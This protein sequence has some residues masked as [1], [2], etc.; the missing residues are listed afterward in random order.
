MVTLPTLNDALSEFFDQLL[1]QYSDAFSNWWKDVKKSMLNVLDSAKGFPIGPNPIKVLIAFSNHLL[2]IVSRFEKLLQDLLTAPRAAV[3]ETALKLALEATP[4]EWNTQ[5]VKRNRAFQD[6]C[7]AIVTGVLDG[8]S[9]GLPLPARLASLITTIK[10]KMTLVKS[11]GTPIALLLKLTVGSIL[12]I[13]LRLLDM[14]LRFISVVAAIVA[15]W[16]LWLFV[17]GVVQDPPKYLKPLGQS[18]PRLKW[19]AHRGQKELFAE[20]KYRVVRRRDPGGVKP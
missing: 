19:Y 6:T 4:P 15:V 5:V 10:S 1:Q 20:S 2:F 13:I 11:P 12:S 7:T 16:A 9:V 14:V 8:G 3:L 17:S 18:A